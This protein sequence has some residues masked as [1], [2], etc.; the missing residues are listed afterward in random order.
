M[1]HTSHLP[2]LPPNRPRTFCA[3]ATFAPAVAHAL[4]ALATAAC[5]ASPPASPVSCAALTFSSAACACASAACCTS[6]TSAV[7][8][9]S[10]LNLSPQCPSCSSQRGSRYPWGMGPR[11]ALPPRTVR[12]HSSRIFI[13]WMSSWMSASSTFLSNSPAACSSSSLVWSGR[14]IAAIMFTACTRNSVISVCFVL[15]APSIPT[16]MGK[17]NGAGAVPPSL[18]H[19]RLPAAPAAPPKTTDPRYASSRPAKATRAHSCATTGASS[20]AELAS[21]PSATAAAPARA[22]A[23]PSAALAAARTAAAAAAGRSTA[24]TAAPHAPAETAAR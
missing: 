4:T 22:A 15:G 21:L 17:W 13:C 5:C 6:S 24:A 8:G 2:T 23:P 11:M 7:S 12:Q 1:H 18:T 16:A 9:K 10:N 19:T 3:L 20:A 14:L